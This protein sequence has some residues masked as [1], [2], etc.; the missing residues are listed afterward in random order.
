MKILVFVLASFFIFSCNKYSEKNG[1]TP[2]IKD[3]NNQDISRGISEENNQMQDERVLIKVDTVPQG[4]FIFLEEG[5]FFITPVTLNLELKEYKLKI[6]RLRY[7]PEEL[8]L[9]VS[10]IKTANDKDV[11]IQLKR[12]TSF[13]KEYYLSYSSR[14]QADGIGKEFCR[15]IYDEDAQ[16]IRIDSYIHNTKNGYYSI[17]LDNNENILTKQFYNNSNETSGSVENFEYNDKNQ[18]VKSWYTG[19]DDVKWDTEYFYR[20]GI[21]EKKISQNEDGTFTFDYIVEVKNGSINSEYTKI[22][23]EKYFPANSTDEERKEAFETDFLPRT[24]YLYQ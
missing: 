23:T 13:T 3:I 6:E 1:Q 24:N 18:P 20:D 21:L 15:Y 10:Q 9:N 12:N 7:Y 4:A 22:V 8:I 14:Q 16:L 11:N 19:L 17:T 2:V 5:Y